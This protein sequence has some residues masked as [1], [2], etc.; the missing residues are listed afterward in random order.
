VTTL[1]VVPDNRGNWR[2]FD[3]TRQGPLS[4]HSTATDAE[5]AALS[6]GGAR[7]DDDVLVHDRYGRT[8]APV[9]Y[10]RERVEEPEFPAGLA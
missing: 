5:V 2:V 10:L 3:E 1:H 8:R 7:G 9:R 4:Q 6:H